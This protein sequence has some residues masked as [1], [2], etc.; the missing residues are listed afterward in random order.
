VREGRISAILRHTLKQN[1]QTNMS[2]TG[3]KHVQSETEADAAA[4]TKA[5]ADEAAWNQ[6]WLLFPTVSQD[7]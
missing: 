3:E 7:S 4:L 2:E 1:G 5:K 6:Q